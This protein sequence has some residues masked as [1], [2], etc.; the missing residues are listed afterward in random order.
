MSV[1]AEVG[2]RRGLSI[3]RCGLV[4]VWSGW[5]VQGEW[6]ADEIVRCALRV[7][8]MIGSRVSVDLDAVME[9]GT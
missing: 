4:D 9:R 3:D 5:L 1:G 8:M 6:T 2:E 7:L